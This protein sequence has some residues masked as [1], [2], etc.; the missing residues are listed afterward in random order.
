M[1]LKLN[2]IVKTFYG[3][4]EPI[5]KGINL[6]LAHGEF[7]I[8]IGSN[9]SGKST[10]MRSISG[11]YDINDGEIILNKNAVIANVTQDVSKG[12]IPE[13]TLLENMV[14]SK[15]LG[16]N[17]SFSFYKNKLSEIT[18]I[19]K[20]LGIGLENYINQPLKAHSR[21]RTITKTADCYSYGNQFIP[22]SFVAR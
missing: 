8:V 9:G 12:T 7:C 22:R 19:V 17:A 3:S 2:N 18:K 20:E 4:F 5:L 21:S 6:H 10:L 15:L 16:K 14:L 1:M 11:E 13:M